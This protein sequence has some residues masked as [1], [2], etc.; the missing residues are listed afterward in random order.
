MKVFDMQN[1]RNTE[2]SLG[3]LFSKLI[4]EQEGVEQKDVTPDYILEQREKKIYPNQTFDLGSRDGGYD[5]FGLTFLTRKEIEK[6][7]SDTN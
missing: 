4:S 6:I 3:S 7:I 5:G 2:E 1:I